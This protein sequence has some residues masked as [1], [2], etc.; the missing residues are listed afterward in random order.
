MEPYKPV[1]KT[2]TVLRK[3][4]EPEDRSK[5]E[6]IKQISKLVTGKDPEPND[7]QE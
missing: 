1:N 3:P 4:Q 6:I 7:K 2:V 5:E